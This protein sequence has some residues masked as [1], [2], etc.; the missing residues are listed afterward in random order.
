[1]A[2]VTLNPT[3]TAIHGRV[4]DRVYKTYG[5]KIIVT[6]APCFDGYVPTPAQR[7]RRNL[8]REA[9]A[10]AQRVHA[11]PAT[12]AIYAAAAQK[13][14]RQ[15]FRVAVS[16][17]LSACTVAI[18]R[19]NACITLLGWQ[20][21]ASIKGGPCTLRAV[22]PP[23]N[24]RNHAPCGPSRRH[25]AR[26]PSPVSRGQNPPILSRSAPEPVAP[27][28]VIRCV[29]RR[30]SPARYAGERRIG[31]DRT[32]RDREKTCHRNTGPPAPSTAHL[33][34]EQSLLTP[35]LEPSIGACFHPIFNPNDLSGICA[36][37]SFHV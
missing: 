20:F 13:L 25:A 7:A 6:R 22:F 34:L 23:G 16:D 10:Y 28:S 19:R 4:G 18:F 3:F 17:Y 26:P 37:S 31:G 27:P 2:I 21:M 35:G 33:A 36:R 12:K 14:R 9:T 24:R 29:S 32:N 1:M 5:G 15:P 30:L 11:H 8:M